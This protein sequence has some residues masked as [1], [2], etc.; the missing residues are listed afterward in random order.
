MTSGYASFDYE[1]IEHR[2]GRL[3]KIRNFSKW[4]ASGCISNDDT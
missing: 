2:E 1:I 4:R 3:S